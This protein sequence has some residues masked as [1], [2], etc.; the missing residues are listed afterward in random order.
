[1]RKLVVTGGASGVGREFVR[2]WFTLDGNCQVVIVD[3]A[4]LPKDLAG[5]SR[6]Y[7]WRF[8]VGDPIA[9]LTLQLHHSG[10]EADT[11]VQ[12]AGVNGI[13][14][15][16]NLD[17]GLWDKVM[18]TNARGL[19]HMVKAFLPGLRKAENPIV[20]NV[21]SN[22]SHMPMTDSCVYNASKGAAH[23]MTLQMAR[24]LTRRDG[25]AVMGV[26]PNKLS[27]TAM[28]DYIDQQVMAS[29]GWTLEEAREY[30][31]NSLLWKKE[32]PTH[33]LAKFMATILSQPETA[34]WLS[35]CIIPFGA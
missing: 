3:P 8:D 26:S 18:D 28:S 10:F 35:G 24:E 19:W 27:G 30:Q 25:I 9:E 29:R 32:T 6:V 13:A 4:D 17:D 16:E 23:I 1:M 31:L 11:L 33:E 20:M 14:S 21:I 5:D 15:I 12:C 22:A 7:H 2:Q 34:K